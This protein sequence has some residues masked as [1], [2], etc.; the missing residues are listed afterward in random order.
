[1]VGVEFTITC[2]LLPPSM[3]YSNLTKLVGRKLQFHGMV[4]VCPAYQVTAVVGLVKLM[5]E[6]GAEIVNRLS[7]VSALQEFAQSRIRKRALEVGVFGI[8]Q[9]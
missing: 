5:V 9:L 7:D 3:E 4:C 8:V 2:Q 1:M 6:L